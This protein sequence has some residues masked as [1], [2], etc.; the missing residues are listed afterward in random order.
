L[1]FARFLNHS[2]QTYRTAM[3]RIPPL[4][5]VV[6]G[7]GPNGLAAAVTLARQGQ[8]VR[9]IEAA[10]QIG[11]GT[12]TRELTVPGVLHDVCSAVHPL[13]LASPFLSSLPLARHGLDWR[14][15]EIDLAH[16]L[17]GGRVAVMVR[18]VHATAAGL[19]PD[20]QAWR[21]TFHPLVNRFDDLATALLGPLANSVRHPVSVA[22]FAPPALLPATGLARWFRTDEARALFAG[23]AAHI[24]APLN[25]AA[26]ASAGLLLIAAGHAR[27]WPVAAGGSQTIA[28]ALASLLR[29]LGGTIETGTV[30]TSFD[31]LP[32]ARVYLFDTSPRAFVRIA[33]WRLPG[34]S[35]RALARWSYGPAAFKLDLAVEGG[36]P[37][38]A[39]PCRRAGTVHVGGRLEEIAAAE[40]DVHR[41]RMPVR[42]FVLVGQQYL[43]DPQRSCG[44]VHP[45]WAYAHVPNGYPFDASEAIIEQIQRFAPGLRD[46]IVGQHALSPAAL[47]AYNPNY[48]G[49]DIATGATSMR[50]LLIR[51]RLAA[52]PYATGIPGVFLCSAATP[53]GPGVHGMCGHHAALR[54]ARY[55]DHRRDS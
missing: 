47:E 3:P 6:V 10:D 39:E 14:W 1:E 29:E 43:C 5:A 28:S 49:G 53:P 45:V 55:L 52:D 8:E 40:S 46:R 25:Q 15:P 41:G 9:V 38:T 7:S 30:I 22:R 31:Q 27:G 42:P 11:G 20:A 24:S 4:D 21:R 36:V 23:T 35:R 17:E 37:W 48:V 32:A 51:P 19:G 44:D 16:P 33:D 2:H 50:Q 26:S 18:A 12:R 54:A 13:A 34:R